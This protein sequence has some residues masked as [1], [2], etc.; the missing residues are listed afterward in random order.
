[1]LATELP[2]MELKTAFQ[3]EL[4]YISELMIDIFVMLVCLA[5]DASACTHMCK[6]ERLRRDV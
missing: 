4:P 6:C 1:M 5:E 3:K 2:G